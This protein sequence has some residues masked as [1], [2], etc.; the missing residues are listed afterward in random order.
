MLVLKK[1]KQME[2]PLWFSF[3]SLPAEDFLEKE[4]PR[5][6]LPLPVYTLVARPENGTHSF[7]VL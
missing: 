3:E 5:L 6:G 4:W 1:A 7:R 2:P